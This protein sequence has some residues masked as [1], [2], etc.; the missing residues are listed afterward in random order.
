MIQAG[1]LV[2]MIL[3]MQT[4]MG[5]V[6]RPDGC[7]C[8]SNGGNSPR[9][10]CD[11]PGC[12]ADATQNCGGDISLFLYYPNIADSDP[13]N[14]GMHPSTVNQ[15]FGGCSCPTSSFHRYAN[16]KTYY[17]AYYDDKSIPNRYFNISSCEDFGNIP[18]N[19]PITYPGANPSRNNVINC[20]RS[21]CE[22]NG[23]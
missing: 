21:C 11:E 10:P 18:T 1:A 6:K 16:S 7:I 8:Y 5:Q 13:T 14:G 19:N 17:N 22:I 3:C 4:A 15:R 9:T 20:C 2:A 12:S 23:D